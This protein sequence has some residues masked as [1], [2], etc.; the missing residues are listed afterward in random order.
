M[1]LVTGFS[2]PS[3]I[4]V[5]NANALLSTEYVEAAVANV[6]EQIRLSRVVST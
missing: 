1:E 2:N 5:I 6:T 4:N 3:R